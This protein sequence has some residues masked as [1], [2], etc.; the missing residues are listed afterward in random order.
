MFFCP[1]REGLCL[2]LKGL[3]KFWVWEWWIRVLLSWQFDSY[4]RD[5]WA[6]PVLL[7]IRLTPNHIHL[8]LCLQP[9]HQAEQREWIN[10]RNWGSGYRRQRKMMTC[11][12]KPVNERGSNF[13]LRLVCSMSFHRTCVKKWK[14][15]QRWSA[16]MFFS[17][18]F[19]SLKAACPSTT[20]SLLLLV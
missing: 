10:Y 3:V 19:W 13:L 5:M 4:G 11:W 17:A 18:G 2:K 9:G 16:A 20:T 15:T 14:W 7:N 6:W 8:C 12:N 1:S